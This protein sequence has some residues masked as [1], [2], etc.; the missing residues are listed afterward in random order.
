MH[1]EKGKKKDMR[2][3]SH[4]QLH[5]AH[6][7]KKSLKMWAV[8]R[9][10]KTVDKSADVMR[11]EKR[12][13]LVDNRNRSITSDSWKRRRTAHPLDIAM[14]ADD[15]DSENDGELLKRF[16]KGA[17]VINDSHKIWAAIFYKTRWSRSMNN[18]RWQTA[19]SQNEAVK[20]TKHCTS[21]DSRPKSTKQSKRH[22][23]LL[24]C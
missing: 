20:V 7:E 8:K 5:K 6:A 23:K 17:Y 15:N 9:F 13:D 2:Q 22:K 18:N 11:N 4:W 24:S 10:R 16:A 12:D 21:E 19:M 14:D 3:M 1:L